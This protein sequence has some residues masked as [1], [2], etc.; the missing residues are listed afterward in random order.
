MAMEDICLGFWNWDIKTGK[1]IYNERFADLVGLKSGS[2]ESDT[3]EFFDRLHPDDKTL[4]LSSILTKLN[5]EKVQFVGNYRI[6]RVTGRWHWVQLRTSV[7]TEKNG[8]PLCVFGILKDIDMDKQVTDNL[9]ALHKSQEMILHHAE[10][11]ILGMNHLGLVTLANPAAERMLG[12]AASDLIGSSLHYKIHHRQLEGSVYSVNDCPICM[13][14]TDSQVHHKI[15][16][17]FWR[18]DRTSFPVEYTSIPILNDQSEL[19]GTVVVFRDI[20]TQIES[21]K[22]RQYL[23][24]QLRQ[25][26]KMETIGQLT[27]GIAHDFNNILCS[28]LGFTYLAKSQ[29]N[30]S[31]SENLFEY[32]NEIETAG[33]KARD[34]I[35]K[36]TVFSHSAKRY[37]ENIQIMDIVDESIR[38]LRPTIPS[39]IAVNTYYEPGIENVSVYVDPMHIQQVVMNL[40]INARDA[41]ED[42]GEISVELKISQENSQVCSSCQSKL[43]G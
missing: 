41:L 27:G 12:W 18:K 1:F 34:L 4:L 29:V 39:S 20:S 8:N 28:M 3:N 10:E 6:A 7:F 16:E 23:E 15:T 31:T 9:G 40:C 43:E 35:S 22:E 2:L 5:Q 26:Q 37:P 17:V 19:S 36:L 14:S 38:L 24:L 21:E 32:L 11:G 13:V 42:G 25:A 33:E 30:T